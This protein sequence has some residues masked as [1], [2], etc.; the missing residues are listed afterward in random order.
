MRLAQYLLA[1]AAAKLGKRAT[2]PPTIDIAKPMQEAAEQ[3]AKESGSPDAFER[4]L[5][6]VLEMEGGY[7]NHPADPGGRTNLGVTQ[8]TWEGW[9]RRSVSAR[10]M[11]G[12]TVKDVAPLYRKN[13]WN[14]VRGDDLPP[15]V[16]LSVFDFGVNAGPARAIRYLQIAVSALP[17]GKFGPQTLRRVQDFTAREGEAAL[18]RAYAAQRC[19]YYR[20]LRTF[21]TFGKGWLNRVRHIEQEALKLAS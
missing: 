6:I 2:L 3:V 15:G 17:D 19:A 13:Y 11:R 20:Q 14:A 12:L 16:A 9:V 18:V 5:P 4:A 8:R 10:E 1:K 7:V 21:G